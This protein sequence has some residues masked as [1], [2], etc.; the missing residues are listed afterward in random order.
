M[1]DSVCGCEREMGEEGGLTQT[2]IS[3]LY[4]PVEYIIFY[5][6]RPEKSVCGERG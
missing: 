3:T 5:I 1:K 4:N 6:I 2:V